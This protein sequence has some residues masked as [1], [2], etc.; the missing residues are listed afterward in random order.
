MRRMTTWRLRRWGVVVGVA[1]TVYLGGCAA[2]DQHRP[3]FHDD[4][5]DI[6]EFSHSR[7]GDSWE[8]DS[9][10]EFLRPEERAAL[11]RSGTSGLRADDLDQPEEEADAD[12]ALPEE[13]QGGPVSRA[14]DKAGKVAVSA[15]GVGISVGMIVAPYFLF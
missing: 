11:R 13:P 3:F 5:K 7:L 12:D 2:Q 9:V 1:V 15:L 4:E 10:A 6:P 8:D 14:L